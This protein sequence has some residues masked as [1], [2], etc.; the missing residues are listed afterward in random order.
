MLRFQFI[1]Q[2]LHFFDTLSDLD[3]QSSVRGRKSFLFFSI[4]C[5]FNL[6]SGD[7]K[8]FLQEIELWAFDFLWIE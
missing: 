6:M 8:L 4:L 7:E 5:L 2:I 3:S 1:Y